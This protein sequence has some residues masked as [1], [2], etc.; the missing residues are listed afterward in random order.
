MKKIV[1]SIINIL[2]S[3]LNLKLTKFNKTNANIPYDIFQDQFFI[4]MINS[5]NEI[6]NKVGLDSEFSY[7]VYNTYLATKYI[8]SNK[9]KGD[10]V[11]CGVFNGRMI[12]TVALTLKLMKEHN[13]KIYLYDTFGGMT[14]PGKFDTKKSRGLSFKR[15]LE[16]QEKNKKNEINLRCYANE[17]KVK[18]IVELTGYKR[19]NF[20]F[21]KGDVINTIPNKNHK[22]IAFLRL[23]TDWYNYFIINHLYKK[24][25]KNGVT[26]QDDYG[27]WD[28]A[29][30]AVNEF[31]GKQKNKPLLLRGPEG[32]RV[33]IKT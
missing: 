19:E 15:N 11:E 28:G 7:K 10:I 5:Y 6:F 22:Y 33:W 29:R 20:I 2:L 21:I 1:S 3:K 13:R 24:V 14:N 23:D 4:K 12:V 27:S 32:D 31:F 18:K 8:V 26:I 16:N 30:K 9:I 17:Q 25:S